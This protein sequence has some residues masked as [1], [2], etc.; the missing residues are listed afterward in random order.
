MIKNY[1]AQRYTLNLSLKSKSS[2]AFFYL[3][4]CDLKTQSDV[5]DG[6]AAL[7]NFRGLPTWFCIHEISVRQKCKSFSKLQLHMGLYHYNQTK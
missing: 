6:K 1:Y 3:H 5:F 4:K 7:V 2:I